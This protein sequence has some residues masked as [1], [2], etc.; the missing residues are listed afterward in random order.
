MR[1]SEESLGYV[2]PEQGH[3]E[4]EEQARLV[5]KEEEAGHAQREREVEEQNREAEKRRLKLND[6]NPSRAVDS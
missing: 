5:H 6:F 1:R 4:L 2:Q 3:T